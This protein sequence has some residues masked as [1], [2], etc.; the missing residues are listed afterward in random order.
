[1]AVGH[2]RKGGA[3]FDRLAVE[4]HDTGAALAGI[5]SD[6]GA[7][8]PQILAQELHKERAGVDI[9][10]YGITVHDQGNFGHQHSLSSALPRCT[11]AQP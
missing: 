3:G 1:M 2:H 6:M 10:G 8:Q 11:K 4:M 5:A 7:G 9:A